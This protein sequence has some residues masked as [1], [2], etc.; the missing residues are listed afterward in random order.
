ML[1]VFRR[2]LLRPAVPRH[3]HRETRDRWKRRQST[4]VPSPWRCTPV[5]GL[6]VFLIHNLIDFV[7][8]AN[9]R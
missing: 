5:I 2:V 6:G 3:V 4:T 9:R 8:E 7:L 1:E